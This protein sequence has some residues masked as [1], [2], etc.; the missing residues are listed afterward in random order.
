MQHFFPARLLAGAFPAD[1]R[2]Y[3]G[4]FRTTLF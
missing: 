4:H 3:R 1:H 2:Q